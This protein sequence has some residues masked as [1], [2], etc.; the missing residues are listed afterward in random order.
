MAKKKAKEEIQEPHQIIFPKTQVSD[1]TGALL[2]IGYLYHSKL[3]NKE[4]Y[5][6]IQQKYNPNHSIRFCGE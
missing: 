3:I 1:T 6:A 5:D 2:L 4:T